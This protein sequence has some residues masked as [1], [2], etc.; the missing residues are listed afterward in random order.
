MDFKLNIAKLT[1]TIDVY[2]KILDK[3]SEEKEKINN[4][5]NRLYEQGWSGQARDK[6][7]EIHRKK[8]MLYTEVEENIKYLKDILENEEKPKAVELKKRSEDFVNKVARNGGGSGGGTSDDE[9]TITLLYSGVDKINNIIDNC[10]DN[11][12][13]RMQRQYDSVND[14]LGQLC[15]TSFGISGDIDEC[16]AAVQEQT[17]NLNDFRDSLGAYNQGVIEMEDNLVSKLSFIQESTNM[18]FKTDYDSGV[19][20]DAEVALIY[21]SSLLTKRI[22]ELSE[23]EKAYLEKVENMLGVENYKKL[24]ELIWSFMVAEIQN[25]HVVDEK[26]L[27]DKF[28]RIKS[29][30][31]ND[32]VIN[33]PL[34]MNTIKQWMT[35]DRR[36]NLPLLRSTIRHTNKQTVPIDYADHIKD[37]INLR[38][39][40][41][42]D[43]LKYLCDFLYDKFIGQIK[44]MNTNIAKISGMD[45][46]YAELYGDFSSGILMESFAAISGAG[47]KS[48]NAL[49]NGETIYEGD[50]V[51]GSGIGNLG[52]KEKIVSEGA[53]NPKAVRDG[54]ARAAEYSKNWGNASLNDA[55]KKYAPNSTPTTTASG[56]KIYTNSDTG[57]QIVYDTKGNY[58]RIE[59]TN[60]VGKRRYLGLDGKDMSNK[61]ENGKQLGRSK[62]EYEAVTHFNNVD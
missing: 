44:N 35:N 53:G 36:V 32:I 6:F 13:N 21:I 10:T 18:S 14:L 7:K 52:G 20:V 39:A 40:P 49:K 42:E 8:Q 59:D 15:Y 2:G 19:N 31:E 24:K 28:D 60:K 55:I 50:V 27:Q 12:Y 33:D 45:S 9:G 4:A 11:H 61:V 43:K 62:A 5:L 48:A 37:S 54:A 51:A 29:L 16:Y 47:I 58:F 56:K 57:I 41:G 23:D 30:L 26:K 3:L 46:K 38:K 17:H 25:V 22:D 1:E 34:K